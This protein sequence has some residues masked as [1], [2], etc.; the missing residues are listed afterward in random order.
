ML[1]SCY[2]FYRIIKFG[3]NAWNIRRIFRW[4]WNIWRHF[5]P[6]EQTID[7]YIAHDAFYR[8]QTCKRLV[9]GS[10]TIW[11]KMSENESNCWHLSIIKNHNF[12]WRLPIKIPKREAQ[13]W[14]SHSLLCLNCTDVVCLDSHSES[15]VYVSQ[16]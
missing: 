16:V 7:G 13:E 8:S 11:S 6:I 10:L 4:N 3:E 15:F 12:V 5:Q 9:F 1:I 14:P 2:S